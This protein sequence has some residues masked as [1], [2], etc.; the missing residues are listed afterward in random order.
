MTIN[1]RIGRVDIFLHIHSNPT[2]PVQSLPC[3]YSINL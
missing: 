2:R 1:L 3:R